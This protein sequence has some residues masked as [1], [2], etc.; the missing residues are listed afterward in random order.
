M[1]FNRESVEN[2]REV[3]NALPKARS[4]PPSPRRAAVN[5][6]FLGSSFQL[7]WMERRA[8]TS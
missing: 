5:L 7:K 6:A 3:G 4:S 1:T 8:R 2:Q